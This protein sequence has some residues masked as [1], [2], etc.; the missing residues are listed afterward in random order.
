MIPQMLDPRARSIGLIVCLAV[1]SVVAGGST[2]SG[3][4]SHTDATL[5][6]K[7]PQEISPAT[8]VDDLSHWIA[9]RHEFGLNADGKY[10]G[11]L[12]SKYPTT[13]SDLGVPLTSDESADIQSR[14]ALNPVSGSMLVKGINSPYFGG[15]AIDQTHPGG[16]IVLKIVAASASSTG[17]TT[18]QAALAALVPPAVALEVQQVPYSYSTL[19]KAYDKVSGDAT[20]NRLSTYN[21]LTVGLEGE[22]LQVTVQA[23][24]PDATLKNLRALYNMPFL[25]VQT[26]NG[27]DF[28]SRNNTSGPVY[29]GEWINRPG[30][31]CSA[32]YSLARGGSSGTSYYE[33]TAGHCGGQGEVW[34]QGKA[35]GQGNMFGTAT[36]NNGFYAFSSSKC[37]C[38]SIGP[39]PK[40]AA[41]SRVYTSNTATSAY[42]GLPSNTN[43][44]NG[45][46]DGRRVC[47]S[48]AAYADAHNGSIVCGT[49]QSQNFS[50]T[51][52]QTG[53][54]PIDHLI[55]SSITTTLNGDSGAPVGDGGD[56]MGIHQGLETDPPYHEVFSRSVY[57]AQFTGATPTF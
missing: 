22:A 15:V 19:Q 30:E 39:V 37:D 28:Q 18:L 4:V 13:T 54:I 26:S 46:G 44:Q 33:I 40:S 53:T 55:T 21:V 35:A 50:E 34:R 32:G 57:I 36:G 47:I 8:T 31:S 43:D 11:S 49:I 17:S 20:A 38:Q 51:V 2:A 9:V 1:A 23:G 56:F 48:G 7:A 42:T 10:L 45:Y 41:T 27:V 12:L 16:A 14:D 3:A 5:L 52:T 25:E 29:G 24:T 6:A